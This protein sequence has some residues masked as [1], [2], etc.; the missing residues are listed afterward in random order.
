METVPIIRAARIHEGLVG[1][2][3]PRSRTVGELA[4]TGTVKLPS[5]FTAAAALRVARLKGVEH[6]LVTDRSMVVGSVSAHALGNARATEPL[7]RLM[8][9]GDVT[10]AA[11]ASEEEAWALMSRRG[12]ECLAVVSGAILLGVVTRGDLAAAAARW[13]AAE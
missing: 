12:V 5:W 6:L 10:I 3:A 2:R 4:S 9:A 8:T 11:E 7:A 1:E 13:E